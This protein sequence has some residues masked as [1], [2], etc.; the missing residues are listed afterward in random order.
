MPLLP[1]DLAAPAAVAVPALLMLCLLIARTRD[2]WFRGSKFIQ[3]RR[4]TVRGLWVLL[5]AEAFPSKRG[6]KGASL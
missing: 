3:P 4:L 5:D 2:Q 1:A 6:Y